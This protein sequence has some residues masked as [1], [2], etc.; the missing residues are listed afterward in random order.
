MFG[1]C[2]VVRS[3]GHAVLGFGVSASPKRRSCELAA[4]LKQIGWAGLA[5]A[6]CGLTAFAAESLLFL[7]DGAAG[8]N[9]KLQGTFAALL[10]VV[11]PQ[12]PL[13]F[14]RVAIAYAAA[15]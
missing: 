6:A 15:G 1:I 7:R 3:I 9:M 4:R 5:G 13:L 14:L 8:L 11:R 10:G 2:V 12:L